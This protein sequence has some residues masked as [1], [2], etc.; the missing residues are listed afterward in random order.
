MIAF[1]VAGHA[2]FGLTY[3]GG[4]SHA[5]AGLG[6]PFVVMMGGLL[7][8]K[9]FDFGY[10]IHSYIE[11]PDPESP[12]GRQYDCEHCVRANEYMTVDMVLDHLKKIM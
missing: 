5:M 9:K 1:G 3:E 7:S 12:C 11:Y 8:F 2:K 10:D 6:V 4:L